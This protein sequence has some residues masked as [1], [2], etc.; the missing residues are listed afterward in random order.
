MYDAADLERIARE[1]VPY[2]GQLGLK[3]ESVGSGEALRSGTDPQTGRDAVGDDEPDGKFPAPSK[4][5]RSDVPRQAAEDRTAAGGGR[6]HNL[7][8]RR[9]R[10]G[11]P[12]HR[13]LCDLGGVSL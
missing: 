8:H 2:V 4:T 13:H 5:R 12:H 10:A 11:L 3:V 7:F 6:G 1:E 9:R